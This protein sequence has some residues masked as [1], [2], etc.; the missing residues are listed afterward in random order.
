MIKTLKLGMMFMLLDSLRHQLIVSCQALPDEPLHS[1]F[2][3]GRMALAAKQAGSVAIRCQSVADIVEIKKV[4]NLPV[5]GL[6]K[7]NYEDSDIYITP[8]KAEV[9]ALI[10]CDCEIIALDA[11]SRIRPNHEKL[12]DLLSL[13]KKAQRLALAD[14]STFE[15]GVNAQNL[16]F[17]IVSTTLSGYTPY[18]PKLEGADFTLIECLTHTLKIPVIAEGRINTTDDLKRAF[19]LGAH[20]VVI[21]SAITRPQVI[22]KKFVDALPKEA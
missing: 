9:E 14:I 16:G 4:T 13:I 10:D 22:T 11:T 18:S 1:S 3:M 6:I 2:I 8:T 12:A 20:A 17:D 21:G 19:T 5:I 15:E 7:Q